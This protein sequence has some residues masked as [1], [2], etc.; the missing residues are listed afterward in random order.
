MVNKIDILGSCAHCFG[1]PYIASIRPESVDIEVLEVRGVAGGEIIEH[2]DSVIRLGEEI[3]DEVGTNESSPGN[4]N[5][6][7]ICDSSTL[8]KSTFRILPRCHTV[9]GRFTFEL[10]MKISNMF[11]YTHAIE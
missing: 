3:I 9:L 8:K 4:E 2:T 1:V 6:D 7:V 10:I 11:C 5:R